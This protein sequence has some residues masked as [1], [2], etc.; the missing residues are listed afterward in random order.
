MLNKVLIIGRLTSDPTLRY[1][2]S[3][4]KV[5][6]FGLAYNRRYTVGEQQ[7]EESHFFD[8]KAYGKMAEGLGARLSKGYMVIVEGRLVQDRWTDK[9]GKAQSRVRILA[10]SIRVINKPRTEEA[11]EEL[12]E[13]IPSEEVP[14]EGPFDMED[15]IPF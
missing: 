4:T 14:P 9:D 10:E 12:S 1:L 2:P 15:E 3:G 11:P 13:E 7:R 8:V 5:V 6:E